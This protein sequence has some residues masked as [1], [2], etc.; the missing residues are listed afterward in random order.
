MMKIPVGGKIVKYFGI[1]A[2][3]VAIELIIFQAIYLVYK[4][5]AVATSLSFVVALVLNWLASR[6]IVF[7]ASTFSKKREFLLIA[8][9]SIVGLGIQLSVG[10]VAVNHLKIYPLIGKVS[11]IFI[12]FFWNY[13]FRERFIFTKKSGK[14]SEQEFANRIDSSLY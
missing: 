14:L 13:W 4:Q 7:G 8:V 10:Y 6:N 9:A 12:S 11:A 1:A 2:V 3:I 5:Y